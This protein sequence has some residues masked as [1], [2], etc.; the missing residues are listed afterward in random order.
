VRNLPLTDFRYGVGG[1]PQLNGDQIARLF[2]HF[3][4][5]LPQDSELKGRTQILII[6]FAFGGDSIAASHLYLTQYIKT[7]RSELS[8]IHALALSMESDL[9]RIKTWYPNLDLFPLQGSCQVQNDPDRFDYFLMM[10]ASRLY[11][12]KSE[13]EGFDIKSPQHLERRPEYLAYQDEIREAK[14]KYRNGLLNDDWT[15]LIFD[16]GQHPE[17]YSEVMSLLKK[18]NHDKTLSDTHLTQL[19]KERISQIVS[20]KRSIQAQLK[21]AHSVE[22][23]Q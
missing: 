22:T 12:D 9:L 14:I 13:Y 3:T 17:H 1:K 2:Q 23:A 16:M 18:A 15:T 7:Q 5:Y 10:M 8:A 4:E 6:D 20:E 19:A 21:K 11:K